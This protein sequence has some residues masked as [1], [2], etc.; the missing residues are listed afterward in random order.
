MV[1]EQHCESHL[2]GIINVMGNQSH[3]NIR[4][5]TRM[6]SES[7]SIDPSIATTMQ[8]PVMISATSIAVGLV[9]AL[10]GL[11][12]HVAICLD[13]QPGQASD[14]TVF[15]KDQLDPVLLGQLSELLTVR[16]PVA[17][18]FLACHVW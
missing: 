8:H 11:L 4:V 16:Q 1:H 12:L 3:Q 7:Y 5:G 15:V 17:N 18:P 13:M 6:I 9:G 2:V 14:A 10:V